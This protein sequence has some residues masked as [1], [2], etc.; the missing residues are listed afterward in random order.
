MN[1]GIENFIIDFGGVLYE[2]D[3][4]RTTSAFRRISTLEI[5]SKI[6]TEIST[7]IIYN[8]EKGDFGDNEFRNIIK[9]KLELNISNEEFDSIWNKTLVAIY[10]KSISILQKLKKIGRLYLLSNT[11]E[12][13]KAKFTK[14]CGEMLSLF[15]ETYFSHKIKKIKPEPEAFEYVL[16]ENN[17]DRKKTLF[18]DDRIENINAAA[19]LGLKTFHVVN[20]GDLSGLLH[21]VNICTQEIQRETAI[22]YDETNN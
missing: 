9:A 14:E 18:I 8:Y 2:I 19:D 17:L 20:Q 15:D 11:N 6:E 22:K 1:H 7:K 21:S 10:P 5:T 16:T 13:H 3:I 4:P 12:I